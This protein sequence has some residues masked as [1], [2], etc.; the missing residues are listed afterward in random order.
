MHARIDGC[1]GVY[2][3]DASMP[4]LRL[5]A[6]PAM[7]R[8][9][10]RSNR[11]EARGGHATSARRLRHGGQSCVSAELGLPRGPRQ[12]RFGLVFLRSRL[13]E[14][15]V[16]GLR[17]PLAE[18]RGDAVKRSLLQIA[19]TAAILAV[20]SLI[21]TGVAPASRA[22]VKANDHTQVIDVNYVGV[23]VTSGRSDV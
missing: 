18:N 21:G 19:R 22:V 12:T 1:S 17:S 15:R 20:I 6:S 5:S 4:S 23:T 16:A 9:D 10:S 14:E 8:K 3:D 7:G 11:T 13:C 2:A